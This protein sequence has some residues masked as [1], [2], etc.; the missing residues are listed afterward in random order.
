MVA[1][2]KPFSWNI[3][4]L[5]PLSPAP[6]P[7]RFLAAP[8][9]DGDGLADIVTWVPPAPG[10]NGTF[11]GILQIFNGSTL[12]NPSA[13]P[14]AMYLRT[15]DVIIE[16]F[17]GD[18]HPDIVTYQ[19]LN[20]RDGRPVEPYMSVALIRWR[21]GPNPFHQPDTIELSGPSIFI[22]Q[23]APRLQAGDIDGD[24]RADIVAAKYDT[25]S[26]SAGHVLVDVFLG[27]LFCF[28]TGDCDIDYEVDLSTELQLSGSDIY[29]GQNGL[30]LNLQGDFDG[31]GRRDIA[32]GYN[33]GNAP[34]RG[35]TS[36]SGFVAV[37]MSTVL[38]RKVFPLWIDTDPGGEVHPQ[39]RNYTLHLDHWPALVDTPTL[40]I[41]FTGLSPGLHIDLE[42]TGSVATSSDPSLIAI[43]GT[44]LFGHNDESDGRY[45]TAAVP[46]RFDWSLPANVWFGLEARFVN[47]SVD[48]KAATARA[49]KFSPDV[50]I[51][52]NPKGEYDGRIVEGAG[53]ARAGVPLNVSNISLA[54]AGPGSFMVPA[55]EFLW[56]ISSP[57]TG[58]RFV[59]VNPFEDS[60]AT[61][62]L[63]TRNASYH[64]SV[65]GA[66][67]SYLRETRAF[68][69]SFDGDLPAY[70]AHLPL[71]A[72]WA[73][74]NSTLVAVEVIDQQSGTD[75]EAVDVSWA[76]AG[77]AFSAWTAVEVY[78][79]ETLDRA[80]A[81]TYLALPEGPGSI[82]R[83]RAWDMVG[84]G[85]VESDNF[86]VN[87]DHT[88]LTFRDP[89][90]EASQWQWF[91][92]VT[93]G[94]RID[95]GPSSL[96]ESSVEYR[97]SK[98]G[99]FEFGPWQP[100]CIPP[101]NP[102]GQVVCIRLF[103]GNGTIF[104]NTGYRISTFGADLSEGDNNW[105]QWRAASNAS[106]ALRYSDPYQVRVDSK[107][108]V[109]VWLRPNGTAIV[110]LSLIRV[111]AGLR[112]GSDPSIAQQG[113]N[114]SAGSTNFRVRAE[115][116]A[117]F[118]SP[119]PLRF[120]SST[121]DA[122]MANFE[123]SFALPRW[124]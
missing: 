82:V 16:D 62:S 2:A 35:R 51:I 14:V 37:M 107:V 111:G 86:T 25:T 89:T 19:T 57:Y 98:G 52:G 116:Q 40:R 102:V 105:V 72:E 99:L 119:L 22:S 41:N 108:P 120:E 27:M 55:S 13:S 8:D 45:W 67:S 32:V 85:P 90:P 114:T 74:G 59:R 7:P 34:E 123:D 83:W 63:T 78:P 80:V 10:A 77:G 96:N 20:V 94:I 33:G 61:P 26:A 12:R 113:I 84:N 110:P 31:D 75:F 38:I 87:V 95:T 65:L 6:R 91:F 68:N 47:S 73:T 17:N 70:G 124:S 24:G 23:P 66:P 18:G 60:W 49:A 53:W 9:F 76:L 117:N 121:R 64:I 79:G 71:D 4:E 36:S 15:P 5:I 3:S 88:N 21:P 43:D 54:F 118:S 92:N 11:V 56:D 1:D 109:F 101:L 50:E 69:L 97:F 115:G 44:T 106:P 103:F 112:D 48:E 122:Y 39:Y 42:Q 29:A 81:R 58:P 104:G 28:D 30:R 46:I 100:G 93:A